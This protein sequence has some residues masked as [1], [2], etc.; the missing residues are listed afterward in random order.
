MSG[1]PGWDAGSKD[2]TSLN[3]IQKFK[4]LNNSRC[5]YLKNYI[6]IGKVKMGLYK[7]TQAIGINLRKVLYYIQDLIRK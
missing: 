1:L 6:R 2:K 5:I 4:S 7:F 3:K